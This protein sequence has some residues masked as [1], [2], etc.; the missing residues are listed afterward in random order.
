MIEE[1]VPSHYQN[2][3]YYEHF[4]EQRAR[5]LNNPSTIEEHDSFFF[6]MEP[7]RSISSTNKPR[8]PSTHSNDSGINSPLAYSRTPVLSLAI[9]VETSTPNPSN[10]QHAQTAELS[11]REHLSPI[12][13]IIR[14]SA[15]NMARKSAKLRSKEPKKIG[16]NQI[17]PILSQC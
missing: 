4:M 9:S 1:N 2:D 17:T 5:D 6:P 14:N 13:Q 10:S 3:N 15:T 16:C 12:Q 11:A 7:L 8:R